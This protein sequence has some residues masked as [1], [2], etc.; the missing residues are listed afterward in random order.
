MFGLFVSGRIDAE[1]LAGVETEHLLLLVVGVVALL[2][3]VARLEERMHVAER[4]RIV[5][6]QSA[7]CCSYGSIE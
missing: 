2:D 5:R 3:Q 4:K 6:L 1:E 7:P